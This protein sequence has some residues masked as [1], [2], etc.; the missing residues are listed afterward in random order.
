MNQCSPFAGSVAHDI[1]GS[2]LAARWLTVPNSNHQISQVH[3]SLARRKERL[4]IIARWVKYVNVHCCFNQ[5]P[6]G[7]QLILG[8]ERT[9]IVGK[10]NYSMQTTTY[11]EHD[12]GEYLI[13]TDCKAGYAC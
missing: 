10:R 9:F 8:C 13:C 5:S 1:S 11:I 4:F 2:A 7:T 3:D 6:V 12:L